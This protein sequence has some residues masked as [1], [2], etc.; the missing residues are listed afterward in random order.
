MKVENYNQL[1]SIKNLIDSLKVMNQV[2]NSEKQLESM[3]VVNFNLLNSHK[4]LIDLQ[5][6]MN[7]VRNL[8]KLLEFMKVE[9][10][11]QLNSLNL[12]KLQLLVSDLFW[13]DQKDQVSLNVQKIMLH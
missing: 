13:Q 12:R 9:S 10:C 4:I 7:K 1:N 5:K 2:K 6:D 3:K 11:S 8:E